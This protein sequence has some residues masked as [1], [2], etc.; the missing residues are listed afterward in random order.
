MFWGSIIWMLS[1][2]ASDPTEDQ[3][4]DG[5][6]FSLLGNEHTGIGFRNDVKHTKTENFL[7]YESF[8]NGGGVAVGDINNDGLQDLYF[9]GNQVEDHLYLNL[10]NLKFKEISDRAGILKR[11]GWSTGVSFADVNGDGF[12]DIYVCKAL[13]DESPELRTNELY[14]NNGDLTFTESAKAYGVDNF[15]RSM[16]TAFFD[17]DKDEDMDMFLVNQPPT[18]GMLSALHGKDWLDTLFSCRLYEN[19]GG[20]FTDIS[21]KAGVNFKGYGLSATSADFNND[22]WTD[23]FVC[24][25]YDAPDMLYINQKDGTFE[26]RVNDAMKHITNFSMGSDIADFNNDG[27]TDLMVLDMLAEDNY[28]QK[29]NMGGMVPVKFWNI[30]KAGGNYQYMFN[31]LHLNRGTNREGNL[32]FSEIGQFANVSA[33]DWS[34]SPLFGDF[35]NDGLIDLFVSNGIK[36]D[37]RNFDGVASAER[38]FK[39]VLS[40]H[41][42]NNPQDKD[43][44]LRDLV[45]FDH[46]ENILPTEPLMNYMYHNLGDLKFRNKAEAWGL[47]R[48]TFSNGAAYGD[49]DNDGDLDLVI[50]NINDF[51]MIY[52]NKS[53]E[54]FKNNYLR[55]KL[56]RDKKPADFY[57]TKIKIDIRET[58]KHYEFSSA[59][60]F[61]SSSEPIAHFGL[62]LDSLIDR[63]TVYWLDGRISQLHNVKANQEIVIDKTTAVEINESEII[64]NDL[65]K[66]ISDELD[67]NYKHTE[68]ELDDFKR[69]MMLPHRMSAFGPALAVGDVDNNGL[70][71]FFIGASFGRAGQ[72]YLQ[73][74]DGKFKQS[75]SLPWIVDVK[76]E[77]VG[78]V[79]FDAEG[80]RD[81]D[82]YVVSGGNEMPAGSNEYKDRLYL[83]DGT[84]NFS[85]AQNVLP[86]IAYSGSRAIPADIDRDGDVDLFVGGRQIPG[87]YPEPASSY[88]LINESG[89]VPKFI[90]ATARLAPELLEIGLVTDA[91][92]SDFDADHD[93]DLIVTGEWMPITVFENVNGKF[94]NATEKLGLEEEVG[95]WFG[96][97]KADFDKDGDDDYV[98]GNLG[99]NY[100]FKAGYDAPFTLHYTDY[101]NNGKGD[102]ILGYFNFG[103]HFPVKGRSASIRQI[104]ILRERYPTYDQFARSTLSEV[105]GEEQLGKALKYSAKTFSSKCLINKGNGNFDRID[106]PVEAQ[107]APVNDFIIDD[108]DSDGNEDILLAGNLYGT[109]IETMRGDAGLG[110][111]LLGSGRGTFKAI[112]P[113]KSGLYLHNDVKHLAPIVISGK[114]AFI[115]ANNN[116]FIRVFE[117]L[118]PL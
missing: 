24:N 96:I 118:D 10:G 33:T 107:L 32:Y 20:Y 45:D 75:Y 102:I 97:E 2:C 41:F 88:I 84:G 4:S 91:V 57:G 31:T 72:I 83:N 80:D 14:I 101:D 100:K 59:S 63:L 9:S 70:D 26:N 103:R 65:V 112:E 1:A 69:E 5:P 68:N 35:D 22:G 55:V 58:C 19:R 86:E 28:R 46:L 95:W 51:G 54:L 12:Q 21:G 48:K 34:W 61:Y 111:F 74:S 18:P 81:L 105:Y 25:D 15:R 94:V 99:E 71:D 82:L 37:L 17:F 13:Y 23:I 30:A 40:E 79:F 50:N 108:F 16:N 43:V 62:G 90:D 78:A 7:I 3:G 114:P 117:F 44:A 47:D 53:N 113:H 29:A 52:E 73:Q 38:Y 66:E 93:L 76:S 92:W 39:V 109:E 110:L 42:K 87:R 98:V 77:D 115:S 56:L 64:A 11:G 89:E 6:V 27:W 60:G 8:Y 116:D 104:P 106:L 36:R 85:K 49:L 67:I